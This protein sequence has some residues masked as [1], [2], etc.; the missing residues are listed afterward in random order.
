MSEAGTN[1]LVPANAIPRSATI[2]GCGRWLLRPNRRRRE[3]PRRCGRDTRVEFLLLVDHDSVPL[4]AMLPPPHRAL[5][6]RWRHRDAGFLM[7]FACCS[8]TSCLPGF[9]GTARRQ[10]E[11]CSPGRDD[12]DQQDRIVVI[13]STTRPACRS[14][15]S[16]SVEFNGAPCSS[17]RQLRSRP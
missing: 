2:Q 13:E 10:P 17:R 14:M 15:T 4:E 3:L 5:Q 7:Q 12:L 16:H 8:F 1:R 9:D 6:A 11:R